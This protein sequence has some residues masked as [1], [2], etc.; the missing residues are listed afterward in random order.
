M[1]VRQ[2]DVD[3]KPLLPLGKKGAGAAAACTLLLLKSVYVLETL[4]TK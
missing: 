2:Q 1:V 3:S 4:S